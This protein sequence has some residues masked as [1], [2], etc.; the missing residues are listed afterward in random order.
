M[1][2]HKGL[3]RAISEKRSSYHGA[4]LEKLISLLHT[5]I[6]QEEKD[7]LGSGLGFRF[8]GGKSAKKEEN[9]KE[10]SHTLNL[11]GRRASERAI[12]SLLVPSL[13]LCVSDV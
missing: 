11:R 6:I 2:L 5:K 4:G 1:F 12:R 8:D 3:I 10:G 7:E 9:E 13:R